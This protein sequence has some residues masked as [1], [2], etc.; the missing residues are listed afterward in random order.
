MIKNLKYMLAAVAIMVAAVSCQE[1]PEDAFSTDPAAPTLAENGSILLTQNTMSESVTWAWT[2]ARFTQ[3]TVSYQ[4]KGV[5]ND[6]TLNIG[7]ATG[8][9]TTTL[10]KSEF[11]SL[12]DQFGA[13][14]NS[15]FVIK[16]YVTATDN[17]GSYDSDQTTVTVYSY[18]DAVSA[19]VTPAADAIVLDMENPEAE[20]ALLTWEPARL[21]YNEDILYSIVASY[22]GGTPVEV[23]SKLSGTSYSTTV[24]ALNELAVAA[25]AP[26][27]QAADI[28]FQVIASSK[29]IESLPSS[30]ATIN[31]T[32]Y[33]ATY[34][35]K[36]YLPG[37]YED[38]DPA[39]AL[40][41]PQSTLTKGLFEAFVDLTTTDG[42]DVKFKFNPD[43]AWSGSDFGSDDLEVT[44][45]GQNNTTIAKGTSGDGNLVVPSGM[46]RVSCDMKHKT[47]ELEKIVSVG[48]IGD[49]VSTGWSSEIKM[50]YDANARTYSVKTTLENG[51][52]FKF[53]INDDWDYSIGDNGSFSGGA[54]YSVEKETGE[55]NVIL[56]V[57]SHPYEVKVLSTA[58]PVQLYLPGSY[59]G[60]TPA[61]APTLQG[62]G[63]GVY[64]GGVQLGTD[65]DTQFKFSPNPAWKDDFG[66]DN[67]VAG[68]DGVYTGTYGAS[69]NLTVPAGY[70]YIT[71]DMTT[72]SVKLEPIK[73]LGIIGGFADNSW[74]SDVTKLTY[75]ATNNVW[76]ATY[77]IASTVEWKIRANDAWSWNRG[78]DLVSA[79]TPFSAV[80]N[81]NN[82]KVPE[83]GTY[84]ITLDLSVNPNKLTVKK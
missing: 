76:T 54:N 36:L 10:S 23:A 19:V 26:E 25:G 81:G 8:N 15:S 65:G 66:C 55:Y 40:S 5:Y 73:S 14:T 53:R 24:D 43:T 13:P 41:I 51:K 3:G 27:E 82:I 17:N 52:S 29:S 74:G 42:S 75:D 50:T 79:G 56:N 63:E 72:T 12:A 45:G 70:Y 4:L 9:L 7:S 49:A 48:I 20:V 83:D 77:T 61:T 37:S 33:K 57:A 21:G 84:T 35:E 78:G 67:L 11:K 18:G 64:E 2:A 22:N 44:V 60:W 30:N 47:I 38:W 46:Y 80:A 69:S 34:P 58:F 71:V 68:E 59:Q 28:D 6:N 16:M 62:N 32:T 39:A 31:I 1:D